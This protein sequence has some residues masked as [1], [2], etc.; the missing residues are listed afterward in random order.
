MQYTLGVDYY[1]EHWNKKRWEVDAKLMQQANITV[2]RIA[3]FSWSILESNEGSYDFSFIEDTIRIFKKY[4]IKIVLG[5][6]SA[7]PPKWMVGKY[8]EIL[9]DDR[10]GNPR[11]FG[12][13]RHYCY[14]S[15]IYKE[16]CRLIV[17]QLAQKF[18]KDENV[19]AWQ[20]DNEFGCQDTAFWALAQRVLTWQY[21]YNRIYY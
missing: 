2:I 8:P 15:M 12:S 19:I 17:E 14:N 13:R 3:E 16:K 4:G 9:Q 5:T 11:L 7:T 6:P 10:F 20:I 18:G 21:M 1:P